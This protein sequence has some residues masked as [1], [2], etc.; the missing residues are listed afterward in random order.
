MDKI[1]NESTRYY[2][3]NYYSVHERCDLYVPFIQKFYELL[4]QDRK[5]GMIVSNQFM[6]AQYGLKI[7]EMITAK[8]GIEKLIDYTNFS[9]FRAKS[10]V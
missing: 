4:K 3:N 1:I 9:P 5:C 6:I 8:W 10:I 7:R 2:K